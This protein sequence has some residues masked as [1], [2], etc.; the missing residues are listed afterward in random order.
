MAMKNTFTQLQTDTTKTAFSRKSQKD[1]YYTRGPSA[2]ITTLYHTITYKPQGSAKPAIQAPT[3]D[4]TTKTPMTKNVHN[5]S[6]HRQTAS[7]TYHNAEY[8]DLA[9]IHGSDNVWT[10]SHHAKSAVQ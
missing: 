2:A 6:K 7:T 9:T 4:T 3:T 1:G 10:M 8:A 5:A